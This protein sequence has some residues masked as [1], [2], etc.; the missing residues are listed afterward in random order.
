MAPMATSLG[1]AGRPSQGN[2]TACL[3]EL[4]NDAFVARAVVGLQRRQDDAGPAATQW[5]DTSGN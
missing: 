3:A 4:C 2:A 1:D 5:G